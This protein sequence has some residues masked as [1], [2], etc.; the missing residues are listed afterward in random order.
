[1]LKAAIS[2]ERVRNKPRSGRRRSLGKAIVAGTFARGATLPGDAELAIR[3]GVSRTVLREASRDARGEGH[4]RGARLASGTRVDGRSTWNFFDADIL[5]WHLENGP[6][7]ASSAT[8]PKCACPSNP[9]HARLACS[10]ATPAD[11]A[12]MRVAGRRY[13]ERQSEEAFALADLEFHMAILEATR[14][15]FMHSVGTLIEAA[16]VTSFRLSSPLWRERTP[17]ECRRQAPPHRRQH[18]GRRRGSRRRRHVRRH[19]RKAASVSISPWT[20]TRL[21]PDPSGDDQGA[22]AVLGEEFELHCVRRL[23]IEDD[24]ALDAPLDRLDAGL[25]L[26]DHAAGEIVPS[27]ISAFA[28]ATV[29]SSISTLFL[30]ST[31][32]TSVRNMRRVAFSAPPRWRAAKVSAL[33]L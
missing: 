22:C 24:D 29:S 14:N 30:S 15:P 16:L 9:M 10:R 23:A 6:T 27:A 12:R 18:R 1:M 13:G 25:D 20:A 7:A 31:P 19:T 32:G 21:Q 17:G 2:G 3:F 8:S 5:R 11:I 26:G 4:D 28:C 33:M